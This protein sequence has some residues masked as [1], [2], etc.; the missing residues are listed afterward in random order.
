MIDSHHHIWDLDHPD[1]RW[2]TPELDRIYR[3]FRLDDY[4]AEARRHGIAGS[5]LVQAADSVAETERLLAVAEAEPAVLGVVGWVDLAAD[6]LEAVL[7]RL[8]RSPWLKGVRP[9]V[10]DIAEDTWLLRAEVARGTALLTRYGMC[11]DALVKPRHLPV[12]RQYL[13]CHPD[14]PV[15]IDHGA[16]PE[17]A[18]GAFDA[19][20]KDLGIIAA[21]TRA[22]CKLSGL[23]TE[24][25]AHWITDDLKP[26][27]EH[28]LDCFGPDR[29]MWGSDWPVVNLAGGLDAWMKAT[30]GLLSELNDEARS[31]VFVRSAQQFYGLTVAGEST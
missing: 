21:E 7:G 9:M 27:A 10:Q 20:A 11:F 22:F 12:L 26:Y 4:H 1:Y 24:A 28:I 8:S 19:W 14:L 15:V 2:L 5:V 17:I 3:S 31:A 18:D 30:H 16:K 13:S 25:K 29:V 6:D 23:V